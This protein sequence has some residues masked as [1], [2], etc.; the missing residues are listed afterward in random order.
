MEKRIFLAVLISLAVLWSWA[1]LAPKLFPEL[2]KKPVPQTTATPSKPSETSTVAAPAATTETAAPAAAVPAPT[3]VVAAAP[4]IPVSASAMTLTRV[5]GQ[6]FIARFS[7]RGAELVSFQLKNFKSK[8]GDLVELVKARDPNRTDFPFAIECQRQDLSRRV[9]SALYVLTDRTEAGAR[10]L[11]YRYAGDGVSVTKTYRIGS[12]YF[13]NFSVA[14]T[15]AVPYRVVIGP[16]I[17]TLDADE[18]DSR[19]TM[20]G[21]GVYQIA[22]SLKDLN[23]EKGGDNFN[24]FENAQ[25]VGVEDNYFLAVL[26]PDKSGGAILRRVEVDGKE[27]RKELIAGLNAARD[28][29][30]TGGAFFG[31]KVATVL[32]KYGLERTLRF[33]TFGIIARFFLEALLWINK[34]TKNYGF[35][36]IVLT[37]LIKIVLYPLQHKWIVSMKK[38]QKIQPKMEQIKSRYKKARSDPEQRNKM[39][40]EMMKLYQAEGINPAGGCLPMVIQFPIFIGFYNLLAHSIE[41]RGAPFMFWIHDLSAKDPYY[42]LPLLMT[43]AMFVQQVMT[44]TTADA[45]QRRMFMIMPLVFGWIFKEFA[46]GLVVYWLVQNILTIVQQMIMNK[47][48]KEHPEELNKEEQ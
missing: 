36:I 38:M 12:E 15:P 20:T 43:V 21:N 2:V 47:W 19:Y 22:D 5:E 29:V 14:M 4:V 10:V 24:Y 28:G 32:D 7:N 1:A 8:N 16:G 35:A 9:N 13:F 37:I 23:R 45:S 48:W 34:F 41:L 39:N 3:P 31:P 33:G 46:A 42:I 25:F 6:D 27:K 26:K 18:T 40:Q 44:P 17:R 11:E 30:V